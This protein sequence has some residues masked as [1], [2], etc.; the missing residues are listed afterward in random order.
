MGLHSRRQDSTSATLQTKWT[1]S[2][3]GLAAGGEAASHPLPHHQPCPYPTVPSPPRSSCAI[4]TPF[5]LCRPRPVPHSP[6]TT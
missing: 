4:P 5:Q 1:S 6:R 2:N 3:A